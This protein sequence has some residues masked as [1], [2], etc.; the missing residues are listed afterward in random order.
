MKWQIDPRSFLV[1]LL[2]SSSLFH[3]RSAHSKQMAPPQATNLPGHVWEVYQQSKKSTDKAI[4]WLL[5]TGGELPEGSSQQISVATLK[6]AA[7]SLQWRNIQASEEVCNSFQEAI[8][9]RRHMTSYY[10]NTEGSLSNE[11]VAHQHFTSV[12]VSK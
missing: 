3:A 5:E 11:T 1:C 4:R 10:R 7:S 12:Y 6:R 9:A 2:F 8:S